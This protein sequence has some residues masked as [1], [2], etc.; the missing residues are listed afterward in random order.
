MLINHQK[1]VINV[2]IWNKFSF[3]FQFSGIR[4]D[5]QFYNS[6]AVGVQI[7]NNVIGNVHMTALWQ[8]FVETTTNANFVADQV[9]ACINTGETEDVIIQNNRCTGSDGACYEGQNLKCCSKIWIF[10][11]NFDFYPK[12]LTTIFDH[13]FVPKTLFYGK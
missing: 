4:S 11:Q 13:D 7:T 12:F 9:P 1:I 3:F 10:V 5:T 8:S 2:E 6:D